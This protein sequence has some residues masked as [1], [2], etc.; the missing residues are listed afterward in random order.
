MVNAVEKNKQGQHMGEHEDKGRQGKVALLLGRQE[1][2]M[3]KWHLSRDPVAIG[4]GAM[5]MPGVRTF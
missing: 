3:W 4:E 5:R 2:S 1:A